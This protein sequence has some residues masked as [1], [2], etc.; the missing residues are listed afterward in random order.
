MV[1]TKKGQVQVPDPT[2][3]YEKQPSER[4]PYKNNA[5]Y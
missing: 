4:R 2:S 3:T 5:L 1:I